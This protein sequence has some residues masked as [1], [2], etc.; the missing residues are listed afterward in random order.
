MSFSGR[1][2]QGPQDWSEE[3]K[4]EEAVRWVVSRS[5]AVRG[6]RGRVSVPGVLWWGP[7]RGLS[8]VP[9]SLLCHVSLLSVSGTLQTQTHLRP[10]APAVSLLNTHLAGSLR[11]LLGE[12]FLNQL[13]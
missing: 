11:S 6:A 10:F 5:W 1:K 12:V 13:V 9:W 2:V 4:G 3:E 7:P 8:L